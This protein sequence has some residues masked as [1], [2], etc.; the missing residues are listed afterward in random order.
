MDVVRGLFKCKLFFAVN[1]EDEYYQRVGGHSS[2]HEISF[3]FR[4]A[5]K[6]DVIESVINK[7]FDLAEQ[8]IKQRVLIT[9]I[10]HFSTPVI[11][12]STDVGPQEFFDGLFK[13]MDIP[14]VPFFDNDELLKKYKQLQPGLKKYEQS[15]A[16]RFFCSPSFGFSSFGSETYCY[17]Y[18]ASHMRIF[19]NMLRI[20]SFVYHCQ[21]DFGQNEVPLTAPTSSVFLGENSQGC[22]CWEED[23]KESWVKIPDGCLFL[24]FGY[25]GLS[26]MWLDN[27]TFGGIEKFMLDNK[28][29]FESL[30]NPWKH[31][32]MNDVAPTI[33]ILSSASQ[34]PDLGAKI[35]LLYCCLEHL[36]VPD[37]DI[38]S[39]NKKY[40]IGGINA[41]KP[42]LLPWF[43]RLYEKRCNYA[44]KGFVL[45]DEKTIGLVIESMNN[46]VTLLVA[47]LT[48]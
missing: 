6:T 29:I 48:I 44:H 19:L 22:Y 42:D 24:S 15:D 37:K 34:I 28:K 21:M 18:S 13:K 31:N 7:Y 20:A 38:R 27:R 3:I 17:W 41:I 36:F 1:S 35:L 39:D 43:N 5:S 32:N 30:K 9:E 26:K 12:P 40:I 14:L 11:N 25:R 47:K 33:D 2:A 10:S 46:I 16:K 45:R 4:W 23:S 8:T